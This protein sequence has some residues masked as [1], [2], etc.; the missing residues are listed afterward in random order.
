MKFRP[1]M[2]L[3]FRDEAQYNSVKAK[4]EKEGVSVNEWV[5]CLVEDAL[6]VRPKASVRPN[7][8][9]EPKPKGKLSPEDYNR[10][11]PSDQLRAMREGK[12]GQ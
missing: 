5:V 11:S 10:L 6:G 7:G 8:K 3:R 9:K 12:Y 2:Q 4:A 1:Q